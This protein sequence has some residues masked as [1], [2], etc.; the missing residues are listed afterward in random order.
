MPQNP[1]YTPIP[2]GSAKIAG[3]VIAALRW[4]LQRIRAAAKP[5]PA[6]AA[7]EVGV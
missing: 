4:I 2:G 5:S 3:K 1:G 6:A 7:Y